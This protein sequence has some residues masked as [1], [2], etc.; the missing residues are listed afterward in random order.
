VRAVFVGQFGSGRMIL[1]G[2][3][4]WQLLRLP[5]K[6]NR[7][8]ILNPSTAVLKTIRRRETERQWMTMEPGQTTGKSGH[9]PQA[10]LIFSAF[11][12]QLPFSPVFSGFLRFSLAKIFLQKDPVASSFWSY[13]ELFGAV[14]SRFFS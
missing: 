3:L 6:K 9:N 1:S 8:K 4:F 5:R 10:F 13:L 11:R 12:V 14:W 7:K 2:N